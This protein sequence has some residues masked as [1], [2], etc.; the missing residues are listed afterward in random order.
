MSGE[1]LCCSTQ[2]W[3]LQQVLPSDCALL[4][5]WLIVEHVSFLLHSSFSLCPLY[6]QALALLKGGVE[7]QP[8]ALL[9]AGLGPCL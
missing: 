4:D 1:S 6:P 3:S 5:I 9:G 2:F 7:V 8:C